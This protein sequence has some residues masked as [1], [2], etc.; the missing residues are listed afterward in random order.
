MSFDPLRLARHVAE[1][2]KPVICA[3]HGSTYDQGLEVALACDVRIADATAKFRM[4]HIL[5]GGKCPGTAELR[6]SPG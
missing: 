5:S 2:E 3:I 1:I 6:D 4:G